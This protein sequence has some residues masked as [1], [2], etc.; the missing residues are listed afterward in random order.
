MFTLTLP[1]DAAFS[2]LSG[3]SSIQVLWQ[4]GTDLHGITAVSNGDSI[5]V[6]GLVFFNGSTATIIARRIDK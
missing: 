2:I 1:A 6:R 5:R 4:P 3:T